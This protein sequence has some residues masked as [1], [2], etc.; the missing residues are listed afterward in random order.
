MRR[1]LS[2]L[3]AA[4]V[5][6]LALV[7]APQPARGADRAPITIL[8]IGDSI[9]VGA[10]PHG[11]V[12]P[13]FQ[14]E[15]GR[16]LTEAGQ[17]HRIIVQAVSGTTCGYWSDKMYDLMINNRP[18]VVLIACGTNDR[19]D[20]RTPSQIE[21]WE[22]MYRSLFDVVFDTSPTALGYPAWV[23][24][25]AGTT[26]PECTDHGPLPW[27]RWAEAVANDAVYRAMRPIDEFGRRMPATIDYQVI[28]EGWLDECGVHP[29]QAG[30]DIMGTLAYN[31]IAPALGLP[32]A[33][34][35]CGM[36]GRRD[37]Y[38]VPARKPCQRLVIE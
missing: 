18:D 4:L 21:T 8:T 19:M 9:T 20:T 22:G 35:P 13:G 12:G 11:T 3:V 23:Q 10:M 16:L 30:Y 6:V 28:P 32:R 2:W 27:L 33:P 1:V 25:S 17:P 38:P 15:L 26:N 29:T 31:T 34:T 36:T 5:A 24:Y 14:R 7:V 37:G